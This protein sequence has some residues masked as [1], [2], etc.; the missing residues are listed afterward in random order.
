ML[1]CVPE[2][3]QLSFPW[4]SYQARFIHLDSR[5]KV[6]AQRDAVGEL[7]PLPLPAV[8]PA[9]PG[10][11]G[12]L[13]P[14]VSAPSPLPARPLLS[15]PSLVSTQRGGSEPANCAWF[16]GAPPPPLWMLA[17]QSGSALGDISTMLTTNSFTSRDLLGRTSNHFP[18]PCLLNQV[19]LRFLQH[20]PSSGSEGHHRTGSFKNSVF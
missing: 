4:A 2:N 5:G 13:Q 10:T 9:L 1:G 3:L 15:P 17:P 16:H 19:S 6:L 11:S 20:L 8:C 14:H 18:K 7:W 12:C